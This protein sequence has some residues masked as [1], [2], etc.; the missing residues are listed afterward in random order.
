MKSERDGYII[1]NMNNFIDIN[2]YM[3]WISTNENL[4]VE[5]WN[6]L[7]PAGIWWQEVKGIFTGQ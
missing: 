2:Q 1:Q 5:T 6:T 3:R 7:T 4:N